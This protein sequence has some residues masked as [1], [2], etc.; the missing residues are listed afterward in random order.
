MK[1]PSRFASSSGRA[2]IGLLGLGLL[3]APAAGEPA[4]SLNVSPF[5]ALAGDLAVTYEHLFDGRHGLVVEAN[6]TRPNGEPDG[7]HEL[8]GALGY[9][10]HWRRRQNSGFVGFM[11]AH[12]SE[13][14]E[15]MSHALQLRTTSLTMNLGKRW[16]IGRHANITF[17]AGAGWGRYAVRAADDT[18]EAHGAAAFLASYLRFIPLAFDGELSAGVVF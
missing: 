4:R 18:P 6:A 12:R 1:T 7:D 3:V 2:A 13:S 8:G 14:G 5:D 15:A 10:W 17:R 9:R 16:M 11:L